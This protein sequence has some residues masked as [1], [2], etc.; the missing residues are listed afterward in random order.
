MGKCSRVDGSGY[1]QYSRTE[2][3]VGQ[4]GAEIYIVK[5]Q[6]TW[7]ESMVQ[8]TGVMVRE[9]YGTGDAMGRGTP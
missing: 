3:H 1:D 2:S 8:E 5:L 6:V 7:G 9:L 4:E